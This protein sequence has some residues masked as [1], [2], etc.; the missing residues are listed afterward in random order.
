M[1]QPRG[2]AKTHT[3]PP[4]GP[5]APAKLTGHPWPAHFFF[6]YPGVGKKPRKLYLCPL[7][8]QGETRK[9]F[10]CR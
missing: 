2:G 1:A 4:R 3:A 5:P 9:F 6:R 7:D 8:C 10:P